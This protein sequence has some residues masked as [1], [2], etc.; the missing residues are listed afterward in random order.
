MCY[1]WGLAVGHLHVHQPMSMSGPIPGDPESPRN[2]KDDDDQFPDFEV[3]KLSGENEHAR[4]RDSIDYESDNPDL[5]L[6]GRDLEGWE[7]VETDS[8][9]EGDGCYDSEDMEEPGEDSHG[10]Y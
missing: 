8:G 5:G 3:D 4:D 7:D 1:H 6:E 2:T 10:L 9:L